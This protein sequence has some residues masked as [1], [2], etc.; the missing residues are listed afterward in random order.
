MNAYLQLLLLRT[1]RAY[2]WLT[3]GLP[4][5][6]P[7]AVLLAA[8]V[9]DRRSVGA[10]SAA[11]AVDVFALTG[12]VAVLFTLLTVGNLTAFLVHDERRG[13]RGRV[14][15]LATV[16]GRHPVAAHLCLASLLAPAGVAA[17]LVVPGAYCVAAGL[18]LR[19]WLAITLT[20]GA[21]ATISG[22]AG[23][24]IGYLLPR[25]AAI[26]ALQL[27][28]GWLSFLVGA[29]LVDAVQANGLPVAAL[30]WLL[31]AHVLTLLVLSPLWRLTSA[32]LW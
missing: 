10:T 32:R 25:V 1:R 15:R 12:M 9:L 28:V 30:A 8:Y 5:L 18:P 6:M 4:L 17:G 14:L 27:T 23:L 20:A 24:W 3:L 21:L 2:L 7:T 22:V 26:I 16:D 29:A 31:A 13:G 19:L 11:E